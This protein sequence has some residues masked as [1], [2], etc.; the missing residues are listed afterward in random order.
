MNKDSVLNPYLLKKKCVPK[1]IEATH[2]HVSLGMPA[3]LSLFMGLN[4]KSP[5]KNNYAYLVL[6]IELQMQCKCTIFISMAGR[7]FKTF[8]K[9]V[10]SDKVEILNQLYVYK[11]WLAA[12]DSAVL[13]WF[14]LVTGFRQV[15]FSFIIYYYNPI[16]QNILLPNCPLN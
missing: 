8:I 12:T 5:S 11:Y 10:V 6:V 9:L 13:S 15:G 1:S 14:G 3:F 7:M 2:A 16:S 4:L